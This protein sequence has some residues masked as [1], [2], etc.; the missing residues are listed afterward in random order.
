MRLFLSLFLA[1]LCLLPS[2]ALAAKVKNIIYIPID[3][4]PVSL[5]YVV[6]TFSFYGVNL[7]V[8]PEN[9]LSSNEHPGNPDA[10]MAWLV[11][12]ASKSNI[13]VIA[14]DSLIYGGLVPSRTHNEDMQLLFKRAQAMNVIKYANKD[15][16]IYVYSSLMRTPRQSTAFVEPPYYEEHGP[17][18]FRLSQLL[19][20]ED[21]QG[22]LDILDATEKKNYLELIPQ[23]HQND[24]FARR[25]K[26]LA[27]HNFLIDSFKA[28]YF[29]SLTIGKDDNAPLSQT[30]FEARTLSK[31]IDAFDANLR[32]LPGIDQLGM[33]LLTKATFAFSLDVPKV[34]LIYAA[35]AGGQTLPAY[36]DQNLSSSVFEQLRLLGA[37]YAF[38]PQDAD[39]TLAVNSPENGITLES[40]DYLNV[41]SVIIR[42][43]NFAKQITTLAD[44]GAKVAV[45]DVCFANGASNSFM[46]SMS[47][48]DAFD[49]IYAYS[50]WNTADN[51][52]GYALAQGLLA[53]GM[54]KSKRTILLKTRLL[55]DWIYQANVR[56][57]VINKYLRTNP[58]KQYSLGRDAKKYV[59]IVGDAMGE[60]V[61]YIPYLNTTKFMVSL[62]WARMF[63]VKIRLP[64]AN[65]Q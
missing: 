14:A 45:A 37:E 16:K 62:P 46:K 13:A 12:N 9:L 18:F 15:M 54:N 40:S 28:G 48:L 53:T 3:N 27:V 11:Q 39:L 10:L 44:N 56:K 23:E 5:S 1:C 57:D 65:Q 64:Y 63:E 59:N 42:D 58:Y 6:E 33:L 26:N 61:S 25:K 36:S 35:G 60:E 55:D 8:P 19:D 49:K 22:Q 7:I 29:N 34:N 50:G 30:H 32:I 21:L 38:S 17:M 52:I 4:R 47:N 2:S 43:Y 31:N 41:S 20:K 24:W 51:T